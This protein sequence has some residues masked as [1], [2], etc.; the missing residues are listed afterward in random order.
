MTGPERDAW[1]AA[2]V[3][4]AAGNGAYGRGG[5]APSGPLALGREIL[6]RAVAAAVPG[7]LARQ[8]RLGLAGVWLRSDA[9][10]PAGAAVLAA[11]HHAWWDGHLVHLLARAGGRPFS[12]VMDEEHL[13][14]FPFF[15]FQGALATGEIRTAVARLRA[16][17]RVAIFPEGALRAPGPVGPLARGAAMLARRGGAP[18]VPLALRVVLRGR[19]RPEA[20]LDLGSAL[21]PAPPGAGGRRASGRAGDEELTARLHV[22]L[23]ELVTGLDRA[24]AAATAEGGG[25]VVPPGFAPLA[26]GARDADRRIAA[27]AALWAGARGRRDARP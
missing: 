2:V 26:R 16:G 24:L 1:R 19:E 21:E 22:A 27:R 4:G 20:Y 18:I 15:R 10:L 17:G 3:P 12:L 23:A 7:V 13:R 6:H 25:A 11:N 5:P 14:T 9:E 8:L